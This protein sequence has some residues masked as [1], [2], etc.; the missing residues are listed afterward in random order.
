MKQRVLLPLLVA[1]MVPVSASAL[2]PAVTGIEI[3]E[4]LEDEVSAVAGPVIGPGIPIGPVVL[5]RMGG[6]SFID[7]PEE[8]LRRK[9]P[10][11][12]RRI[13][14]MRRRIEAASYR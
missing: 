13:E 14:A 7:I 12:R 9:A 3:E 1:M 11:V 6:R 10:W 2:P 8:E 5:P 4:M